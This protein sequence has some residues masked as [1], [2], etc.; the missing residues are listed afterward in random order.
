MAKK[1]PAQPAQPKVSQL[2]LPISDSPLVI[3]LP[4]GQ[5]L[6]IGKMAEGSVIEVATW[7]GTGRPDSRT[8]RLM[9][10]MSTGASQEPASE[11]TSPV[12]SKPQGF[13][14]YLELVRNL[15][16]GALSLI[17]KLPFG[18]LMKIKLPKIESSTPKP[19]EI[20]EEN[21]GEV[22][23]WLATILRKVETDD[24][25]DPRFRNSIKTKQK[26]APQK[27]K[28]APTPRRTVKGKK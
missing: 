14:K 1:Q 27:K 18:K 9:L 16:K 19:M 22:D 5:K 6:V 12:P 20:K 28:A 26:V 11:T 21:Q 23:D 8:S 25:I 17:L 2:P 10:G 24:K 7:R 3:D 13:A 15:L 4:D